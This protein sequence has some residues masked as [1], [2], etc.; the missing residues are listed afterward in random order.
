MNER[1]GGPT[2]TDMSAA[3]SGSQLRSRLLGIGYRMTGSR[4]DAEDLVQE[5][6]LRVHLVQQQKQIESIDAYATTVLTRLAIDHLRSARVRRETYVGPWLPEPV[7]TDPGGSA[8]VAVELSESLSLA[9]LVTLESL[10]PVERAALLLHD[11]FAYEYSEI[12]TILERSEPA[13]RQLVSRARARVREARPR[14]DVDPT[15]HEELLRRFIEACGEGDLDDIISFLTDDV[16]L[17]TDGGADVRA[18]R[19]PIRGSFRVARVTRRVV[20]RRVGVVPMRYLTVN[21]TPGFAFFNGDGTVM[22]VGTIDVRDGRIQKIAWVI[23]PE[24]LGWIDPT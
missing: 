21:G 18:A 24:K 7:A 12:A 9:F 23:N 11:V 6:L 15:K 4:T 22:S 1:S 8:E 5:T 20:G 16:V 3:P 2:L 19:F 14:F 10:G 17:L 13:C